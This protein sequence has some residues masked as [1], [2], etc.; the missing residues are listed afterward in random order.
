M[1]TVLNVFIIINLLYLL[2]LA[3]SLLD[4]A[5]S[6]QVS[7]GPSQVSAGHSQ[8]SADSLICVST[9]SNRPLKA[10]CFLEILTV[11]NSIKK[12]SATS[13]EILTVCNSIEKLSATSPE[14]LT[15]H[16]SKEKFSA[17]SR[18]FICST[19]ETGVSLGNLSVSYAMCNAVILRQSDMLGAML[20]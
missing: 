6:R 5:R 1:L 4:M 2:D 15:V 14:I 18:S 19:Y 10:F 20:N 17:T 12:F 3:R 9:F 11:H 7:A 16:N 8:V 13:Q